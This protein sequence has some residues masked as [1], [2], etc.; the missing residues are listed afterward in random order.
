MSAFKPNVT[1]GGCTPYCLFDLDKDP[2]ESH[3]L[4]DDPQ[5]AHIIRNMS[6]RLDYWGNKGP[7]PAI[8]YV[9]GQDDWKAA[10]QRMCAGM[11]KTGFLEPLEYYASQDP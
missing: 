5:Y 2:S 1:K 8:A 11:N 10:Q 7:N 9:Y 3:N 4:A 6:T